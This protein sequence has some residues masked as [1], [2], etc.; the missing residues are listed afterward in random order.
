M[1]PTVR[2]AVSIATLCLWWSALLA[3]SAQAQTSTPTHQPTTEAQHPTPDA[4]MQLAGDPQAV[5]PSWTGF[6]STDQQARSEE[7]CLTAA[8]A[9]LKGRLLLTQAHEALAR[10]AKRFAEAEELAR[11]PY[12]RV[13]TIPI[14]IHVPISIPDK[15]LKCAGAYDLCAYK[16][17]PGGQPPK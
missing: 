8:E 6:C 11:I 14:S 16:R 3:T 7:T 12:K 5:Y 1:S 9:R 17:I 13:K 15:P 2:S 10:D 4:H